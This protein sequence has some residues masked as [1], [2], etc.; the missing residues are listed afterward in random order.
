MTDVPTSIW[1]LFCVALVTLLVL[2]LAVFHRGAREI[3]KKSALVWT[4]VWMSLAAG[5]TAL[6]YFWRGG[7]S[8]MEFAT[9][10]LIE[11]SLSMDNVFVFAVIFSSFAV[12]PIYRHRVLF[13]GVLTALILRLVMI[14]AGAAL[15]ERFSWVLY[16]FA[17]L[18]LFTGIKLLLNKGG[19]TPPDRH[20]AVRAF[21]KFFPVTETFEGERFF[22]RRLGKLWAT[23]LAIVLVAVE[24]SDVLFAL[25]SV[26]AIFAVTKDPFIVFT[27]NAFAI[28]GLRS[29][30][31]LLE[32]ALDRF[33]LLKYGL[34]LILCFV[35]V[36]ML[37][38][39]TAFAI[40]TPLSL[41]V[42][43]LTLGGSIA[44]SMLRPPRLDA[45]AS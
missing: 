7:V 12:P 30:Y 3:S 5:F 24:A 19:S 45:P 41:A 10:Y 37:L 23:P 29:I 38:A 32:G 8:A 11:F 2:D 14:L 20:P 25:D 22:V 1:I 42:I 16:V 36:K 44:I 43:V 18:L 6:L 21:R 31:F 13:W 40:P 28:L 15:I 4:T 17:A 26:P 9:G 35:G 39:H 27:S 34:G 33:H